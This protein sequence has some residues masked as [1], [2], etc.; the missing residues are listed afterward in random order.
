MSKLVEA[1]CRSIGDD[2]SRKIDPASDS[3]FRGVFC[4]PPEDILEDVL[5][6]A[7]DKGGLE[8]GSPEGL[9]NPILLPSRNCPD[10]DDLGSSGRCTDSH[11][12]KV[13]TSER[14]RFLILLPP[15]NPMNESMETTIQQMG[16]P[17]GESRFA[18]RT[19]YFERL[20]T[21]AIALWDDKSAEAY[22]GLAKEVIRGEHAL[23]DEESQDS[24]HQ[25]GL[26]QRLFDLGVDGASSHE[27]IMSI[28][29]LVSCEQSQTEYKEHRKIHDSLGDLLESAG[30]RQGFEILKNRASE[31]LHSSLDRC[32][33]HIRAQCQSGSDFKEA[34][35]S[36]YSPFAATG[37]GVGL[38]DWW[39]VLSMDVWMGLLETSS[40][41]ARKDLVV[42]CTNPVVPEGK[43]VP[44]VVQSSALFEV[45]HVDG[46]DQ[47]P[48]MVSRRVGRRA[49]EDL[50][51]FPRPVGGE[52][53]VWDD[54]SPPEHP[55]HLEYSFEV[56]PVA[57]EET[58]PAKVKL[59]ALDSYEIG[60]VPYCRSAAKI[61]PFKARKKKGGKKGTKKSG[62]ASDAGMKYESTLEVHGMGMHQID[63]YTA[64]DLVLSEEMTGFEVTSE[65]DVNVAKPI[66]SSGDHHA[67]SVIETDEECK[68]LFCASK[69][70]ESSLDYWLNIEADDQAPIGAESEFDRL[71]IEHQKKVSKERGGATIEPPGARCS[72]LQRW[73][74]SSED[75][76]R[77][78][79]IGPDFEHKWTQPDWSGKAIISGED[80]L[81]DPRPAK[82]E[83]TPSEAFLGLRSKLLKRIEND[84]QSGFRLLEEVNLGDLM[85]EKEGDGFGVLIENYIA[86]YADWL[87][88]DYESAAWCD[89]VAAC[90]SDASGGSLNPDPYAIILSPLHPVRLAWHC[91]AQRILKEALDEHAPCP[92][93]STLDPH[94]FPDCMMLPV[95]NTS[96][97][98]KAL[99]YLAVGCSSDYWH[100]MW[101]CDSFD[102]LASQ[103][104]PAL[105]DSW[106]GLTVDGLAAGF[107]G[108]QVVRSIDEMRRIYSAKSTLRILV[109]S[110]SSGA[111]SCNEGI[112]AWAA[113]N[114]GP[115]S[116]PWFGAG[117]AR[118]D[119]V[120]AR[121]EQLQPPESHVARMGELSGG[122]LSWYTSHKGERVS[123]LA[124]LAHLGTAN[125][126]L[127]SHNLRT[128]VGRHGLSRWRIRRQTGEGGKF[129]A[130][131]RV[132]KSISPVP[133]LA[134]P[135]VEANFLLEARFAEIA[136]AHVFAPNLSTLTRSLDNA[137]YC[138]VSSSTLDPA[139]FF[140]QMANFYLWDYDLPSYS[141]RAGE[142]SGYYL[143]AAETPTMGEAITAALQVLRNDPELNRSKELVHSLLVEIANRGMPT[144][145]RLTSGGTAA[146]GEVGMLVALRLLQGEFIKGNPTPGIVPVRDQSN[147]RLTLIIPV[148]PFAGHFN[149]L[150]RSMG[151]QSQER[152]DLLVCSIEFEGT[153]EPQFIQLTPVEVKARSG[154]MAAS[155]CKLALQQ[156]S[157]FGAFL[158]ELWKLSGSHE[159]WGIAWKHLLCSWVDYGF[160]VY[161]QLETF[162][163]DPEW[164]VCHQNVLASILEDDLATAIDTR[165]RLVVVDSRNQSDL[166]DSDQDGYHETLIVNHADAHK[167]IAT[168][169]DSIIPM[170]VEKLGNWN[171]A[172]AKPLDTEKPT[173]EGSGP[174]V[175]AKREDEGD[176]GDYDDTDQD[177]EGDTDSNPPEDPSPPGTGDAG[178]GK[179]E[180]NESSSAHSD[181]SG[182]S[183]SAVVEKAEETLD[184]G[185]GVR[186]GVGV[187]IG[188][189]TQR[190][191]FLHPSNTNLNQL[192]I[193][194]IGDLG[195]GKTQL[196]QALLFNLNR[197]AG[198]N[199]GVAPNILIFDYK[200]DYSK[201]LFV[202][203]TG[204]RVVSPTDIPLNLFDTSTSV[205][206]KNPRLER[207][208]F[209]ND[210]LS[211]IFSGIGFKQKQQLTMAIMSAY[212]R[213]EING[214]A[215]PTVKDVF[216]KYAEACGS[217]YDSPYSIMYNLVKRGVFVESHEK[218]IPFKE[219]LNGVVVIDLAELGQ[220]DDTK[221]ML[222]A[223][224]LNLFYENMLRTE[225]KPFLGTNPSL[226]AIDSFLLVDEA[227]NIMRYEFSVLRRILLQ[228]REFGVGVVLASQYP[229]HFSTKHENY[230]EALRSWFIHK[231]PDISV[232]QL[233]A[234]GFPQVNKDVAERVKELEV[235][236]CLYRSY[237]VEGEFMRG[238]PLF[239]LL[240]SM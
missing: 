232:K 174:V 223:I 82:Q 26:L 47:R 219:F 8:I 41:K 148:D 29:G 43:G 210:I 116:D 140:G 171:T 110:D 61:R 153:N 65:K 11:L 79:I 194:V 68:Y 145:K 233:Q 27:R 124:I 71:V 118:V 96:G 5:K 173:V 147:Q 60:V 108:Q 115:D 130:E 169:E 72:D 220:D 38:P 179:E 56:C 40:S 204:A 127:E 137:K 69:L 16:I 2:L 20:L 189:I 160:R 213:A 122:T 177:P 238:N 201:S 240:K 211:K 23:L 112:E 198:G 106:F 107:S 188:G 104:F 109:D 156:A 44:A 111:C 133:G 98:T 152:P 206:E 119:V 150:R 236:E 95:K 102:D 134:E 80:L 227:D 81:Q 187:S 30:I 181:E 1:L 216:E 183:Q 88:D 208:L 215:A 35:T 117:P 85:K 195:T 231:V 172:G 202:E 58:K 186:F 73:I 214:A 78:L 138:A 203:A 193:G 196:L 225:K 90:K 105:F 217:D 63:L 166:L 136:D 163:H 25:W 18:Y 218:T 103:D 39:K 224:F 51:T 4:G 66:N 125:P 151:D 54:Q 67:V 12:V 199:R 3:H 168:P 6:T 24:T 146:L 55:S 62:G 158:S 159:I 205:D 9:L 86:A 190:E 178:T 91:Q 89:V 141:R 129:I 142:N 237:G 59:I 74:L 209:F 185:E 97:G 36:S 165:G 114:L 52:A 83:M 180:D 48:V 45:S 92:A 123:D 46:D 155:D 32:M 182:D 128:A 99:G 184:A 144:L 17:P 101:N 34:S 212:E 75:S 76:Y 197:C 7:I 15:G 113:G 235:H 50:G 14:K 33:Q 120:D 13:R 229:S 121:E 64:A 234:M 175:P 162:R 37:S 57:D 164:S 149:A 239:E 21:H 176:N 222:V 143:L 84:G 77:P 192:N 126:K 10:P 157:K 94:T 228:G 42:R 230:A 226:R 19:P 70:G 167:V 170:I 131:T 132:G 93:A 191:L 31:D 207:C 53:L 100:V 22:V 161:G 28:L 49:P 200:K 154:A 221:N 87:R 139:C 135:L